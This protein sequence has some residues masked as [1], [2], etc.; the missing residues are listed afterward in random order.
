MAHTGAAAADP[1]FAAIERHRETL[2]AFEDALKRTDE[3]VARNEGREV[4]QA[5]LDA[6]AA[7]GRAESDALDAL[8]AL[9]PVTPAGARAAIEYLT[10]HEGG[11]HV[12]AYRPTLLES[13][14]LAG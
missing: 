13:P 9:P 10:A 3:L 8:L 7:A 12:E 14:L 5:D 1:V 2:P 4:T 6:D 11:Y